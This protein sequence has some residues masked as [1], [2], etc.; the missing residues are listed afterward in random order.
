MLTLVYQCISGLLF[1]CFCFPFGPPLL[2]FLFSKEKEER[3]RRGRG[4]PKGKPKAKLIMSLA[5]VK[6]SKLS[7]YQQ[8]TKYK[9]RVGS[10]VTIRTLSS[11]T[12]S[13]LH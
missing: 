3:T 10:S 8:E 9:C 4:G 11:K 2:S 12:Q 7:G 13:E 1:V 5:K 6:N